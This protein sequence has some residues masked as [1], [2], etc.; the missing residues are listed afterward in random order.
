MFHTSRV[1][2]VEGKYDQIRLSAL[3]DALILQTDGF[4]IFT[5]KENQQFIKKT[6]LEK[7]LMIITDSDAAGFQIRH[8]LE[9][10]A[11]G[12]DIINVFIPD[13]YGREPRKAQSSKEGKLGV[14]GMPTEALEEALRKSGVFEETDAPHPD[15]ITYT[16]LYEAGLS[17]T[18]NSAERR[19]GFLRFCD[20][21]ERLT[22][23]AL[24]K[25]LNAFM[26]KDEFIKQLKSFNG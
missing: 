13:I 8:F 15:P 26:T 1:I 14:E 11:D 21:P 16:D 18:A 7:G 24:L 6:A 4:G 2:V 9:K 12:A 23:A 3:T 22:G 19:R 17:G 25:A 5:N 20:L 10:I